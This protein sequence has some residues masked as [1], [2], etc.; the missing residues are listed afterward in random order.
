VSDL[1]ASSG[2]DLELF[3]PGDIVGSARKRLGD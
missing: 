2:V 3:E 1:A